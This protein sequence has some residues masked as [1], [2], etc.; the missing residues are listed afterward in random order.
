MYTLAKT[1]DNSDPISS[2]SSC[3]YMQDSISRQVVSAEKVYI[4]IRLSFG[5]LYVLPARDPQPIFLRTL[6][7]ATVG[8]LVKRPTTSRLT[9]NLECMGA[10]LIFSTKLTELLIYMENLPNNGMTI[11][12]RKRLNRW[13]VELLLLIMGLNGI[14]FLRVL[15][16]PYMCRGLI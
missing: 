1:G 5:Y 13:H 15:G 12:T 16:R 3:R 11:S 9:I 7:V 14:S 10:L 8:T 2:P 6:S 4:S